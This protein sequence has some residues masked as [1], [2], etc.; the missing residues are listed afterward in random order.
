MMHL[1]LMALGCVQPTSNEAAPLAVEDVTA[2]PQEGTPTEPDP[3]A[4]EATFSGEAVGVESCR[5]GICEVAEGPFWMGEA[6]PAEPD[7][8]PVR[9]VT[10]SAYSIDQTEVTWAAWDTCVLA[11]QCVEAKEHCESPTDGDRSKQPVT[12]VAWAE[13]RAYCSWAGGRLPTEAEWEKAARG[14]E[15]ATW[16]W[17]SAPRDC[18]LANYRYSSSYCFYGPVEVGSF[19]QVQSAFGLYDTVGNVWEW[20]EDWYSP[21]AYADGPEIDPPG[22]QDCEDATDPQACSFKVIRGGSFTT[23]TEVT[24]A[25]SRSLSGPLVADDNIGFR[26]AYD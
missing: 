3:C 14:T 16:A 10:L 17:G 2:A 6:N 26:C 13:A 24:R 15:G 23:T 18:N 4:V 8:C 11:G 9:Q 22:P 5:V 21:T 7:E 12:C 20:V 25:A 1:V 19:S